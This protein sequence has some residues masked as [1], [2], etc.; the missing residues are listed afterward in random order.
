MNC[1]RAGGPPP[2]RRCMSLRESL[3]AVWEARGDAVVITAMGAAR[4]WMELGRHPLDWVYVPSSMGQAPA[5]G[6][7]LALAC[8]ER[9]IIVAHGDGSMLMNLGSLVTIA[10]HPAENLVLLVFDNAA[11]E[12]TGAQRTPAAV[13][14]GIDLAAIARACGIGA[15]FSFEEIT[16]WKAGIGE[17]LS[18]KGPTVAVLKVAPVPGAA[19]PRSPGLA[20]QR[21]KEFAAALREH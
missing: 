15:V 4:E 20:R 18:A 13:A 10:A 3:A 1:K 7:G 11:Y 6:L 5:L 8:P 12:V 19:G 9:K 17:V 16:A 14:E 2:P 21:V